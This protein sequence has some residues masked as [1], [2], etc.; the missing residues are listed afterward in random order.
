M[1]V[2]PIR[3]QY[4]HVRLH[5]YLSS[6]PKTLLQRLGMF[7]NRCKEFCHEVLQNALNSKCST[8]QLGVSYAKQKLDVDGERK[9]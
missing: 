3:M 8:Q 5:A 9:T 6:F 1:N 7:A 4:S 2:L